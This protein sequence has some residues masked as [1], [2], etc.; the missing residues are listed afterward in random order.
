MN[1]HWHQYQP[2]ATKLLVLVNMQSHKPGR[3]LATRS[4]AIVAAPLNEVFTKMVNDVEFAPSTC[5][6]SPSSRHHAQ[7]EAF[8]LNTR[9]R[10]HIYR[11]RLAQYSSLCP[12]RRRNAGGSEASLADGVR[13]IK[14]IQVSGSPHALSPPTS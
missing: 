14:A 8:K 2:G 1:K 9:I 4:Y 7:V 10:L 3:K 13:R 12:T 6:Q 5:T 11:S